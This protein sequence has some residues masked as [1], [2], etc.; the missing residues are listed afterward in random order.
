M[1]TNCELSRRAA[2][3]RGNE[4]AESNATT[5]NRCYITGEHRGRDGGIALFGGIDQ[6]VEGGTV[7]AGRAVRA[8]GGFD[9]IVVPVHDV[10]HR[11]H[12]ER[13]QQA[14]EEDSQ[15]CGRM[16]CQVEDGHNDW[17]D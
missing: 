12:R 1:E 15:P 14:G 16:A 8:E 10:S 9:R 2:R 11:I 4:R 5:G 3:L 7:T 13:E 17:R 6:A